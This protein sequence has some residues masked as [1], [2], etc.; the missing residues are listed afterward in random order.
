MINLPDPMCSVNRP[1][2]AHVHRCYYIHIIHLCRD[3]LPLVKLDSSA[4][5]LLQRKGVAA[6]ASFAGYEGERLAAHSSIQSH[7]YSSSLSIIN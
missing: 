4:L 6:S 1:L 3:C 2:H 5:Y 7:M